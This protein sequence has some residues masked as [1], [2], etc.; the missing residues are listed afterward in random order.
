MNLR[1]QIVDDLTKSVSGVVGKWVGRVEVFRSDK[2]EHGDYSTNLALRLAQGKLLIKRD[3]YQSAIEIAK[4]LADSMESQAY[5]EKSE[6]KEPGFINFYI[7]DQVWQEQVSDVIKV[8]FKYGSNQLGKGKKGS[9][10]IY[11]RQPNRSA[12]LW[13][14]S[15][16]ANW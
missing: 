11:K 10:R 6:V 16:R 1:D 8:G 2:V 3:G 14:C 5:I 7:K 12:A 13:Q 9:Y 15:R 4:K